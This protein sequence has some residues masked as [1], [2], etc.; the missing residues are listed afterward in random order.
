VLDHRPGGHGD[1]VAARRQFF[2]RSAVCYL[3]QLSFYGPDIR[4][5]SKKWWWT[6]SEDMET[7]I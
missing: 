2:L 1:G 6:M 5:E 7:K 3:L 4:A